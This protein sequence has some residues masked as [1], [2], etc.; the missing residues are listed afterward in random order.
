LLLLA[1]PNYQFFL[2]LF[3]WWVV[4]NLCA[5]FSFP[6]ICGNQLLSLS[7]STKK[8]EARLNKEHG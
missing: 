4:E 1:F 3:F 2:F 5:T 8:E 7:L 6:S